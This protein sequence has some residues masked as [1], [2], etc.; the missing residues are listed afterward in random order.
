[1]NLSINNITKFYGD[2]LVLDNI[3]I[4]IKN[5]KAISIIGKSGSGKSTL[6]RI[7]AQIDTLNSGS[8]KVNDSCLDQKS[9][10]EKIGVVFQ[11]HNLF[12]HLSI[13]RNIT[14]ILEKIKKIDIL[15]AEEIAENSLNQVSLLKFK[16]Q[17]PGNIS[18]GQQQR[19][20]IAR[21]I[22]TK[23]NLIFLD[24]PTASI[25]PLLTHEVLEC[26]DKLKNNGTDFI[27]VTHEINFVKKISDYIIFIGNGK[28]IEHG[29][30]ILINP[31]SDELREFILKTK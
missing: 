8:F 26:I 11:Q 14:I 19:A 13:K 24:E 3:S 7:L 22:A 31:K 12:P 30:N 20:A 2:T 10:Q 9:Y 28:I 27:F 16:D 4:E 17:I 25:D 21:A 18:G 29:E 6:L 23:P 15:T 5:K 1:M